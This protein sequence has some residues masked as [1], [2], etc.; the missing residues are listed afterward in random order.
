MQ[1]QLIYKNKDKQVLLQEDDLKNIDKFTS[2][3][4]NA[5]ELKNYYQQYL[6]SPE[7]NFTITYDPM[8]LPLTE[9]YYYPFSEESAIKELSVMYKSF[10]L[11][12]EQS[13]LIKDLKISLQS[14]KNQENLYNEL[15]D[16]LSSEDN[17]YYQYGI[18]TKNYAMCL[19]ILNK[20]I[21]ARTSGMEGYFFT[22]YLRD[23][24]KNSKIKEA[25]NTK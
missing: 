19:E 25:N 10:S 16:F 23:C 8:T 9:M 13:S 4:T 24:L 15:Q 21:Y 11:K 14:V 17:L 22:R 2:N 1:G 5:E 12:P 3:F 6:L 7:G 20:H 18:V